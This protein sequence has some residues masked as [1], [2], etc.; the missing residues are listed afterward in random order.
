MKQHR[1]IQERSSR[2]IE[3]MWSHPTEKKMV[4]LQQRRAT[5]VRDSG[6]P[7][8]SRATSESNSETLNTEQ[9]ECAAVEHMR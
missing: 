2:T 3:M 4:Y 1:V 5:P 7:G 6:I 8:T 9:P